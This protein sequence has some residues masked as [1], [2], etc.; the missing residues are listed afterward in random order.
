MKVKLKDVIHFYLGKEFLANFFIENVICK[1]VNVSED[2][3]MYAIGKSKD[4]HP[5]RVISGELILRP[6]SSMTEE[7]AKELYLISPY[8]KGRSTIKSVK[9]KENIVGYQPNI[10]EI[11]WAGV[12]GNHQSSYASGRDILYLNQLDANQFAYLLKEGF[13]LFNLIKNK[14]AID[15][16][17]LKQNN[18]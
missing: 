9:I 14:K 5:F 13:D 11:Y 17:T 3:S 18:E 12:E 2:G 15:K 7:E 4:G 16:T 6:L 1:I 10:I 8:S